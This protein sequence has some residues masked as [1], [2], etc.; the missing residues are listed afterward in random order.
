MAA[1]KP[2]AIFD[3]DGTFIRSS[4]LIE[5]CYRLADKK[6]FPPRVKMKLQKTRDAWEERHGEYAS[7]LM[8]VVDEY[9]RYIQGQEAHAIQLVGELVAQEQCHRVYVFTRDLIQLLHKKNTHYLVAITGSPKPSVDPFTR[10]WNFNHVVCSE[11]EVANGKYTDKRLNLPFDNKDQ[12]VKQ[13]LR[14]HPELTDT[15]SIGVGD[16]QGDVGF[17]NMVTHPLAFNP[18]LQLFLEAQ[19]KDWD[20]ITERKDVITRRGDLISAADWLAERGF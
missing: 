6:I 12:I 10:F 4:M 9:Y 18:N 5:L 13:L 7:Y 3:V 16:T 14:D 2:L 1:K 17:L 8:A 19:K 20:I 15:G 11:A